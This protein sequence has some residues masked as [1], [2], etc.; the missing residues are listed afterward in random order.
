[1]EILKKFKVRNVAG[2]NLIL[3]Q[4]NNAGDMSKVVAL[5]ATSMFL[6]NSFQ[7][8]TFELQDVADALCREYE[9]EASVALND[10]QMW[11]DKLKQQGIIQ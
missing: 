8:K 4:G 1:M 5:N 9:V 2:E 11:V 6:W 10:A 3:L 7:D